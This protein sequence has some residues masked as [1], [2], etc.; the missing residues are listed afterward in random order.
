M[1]KDIVGFTS[2]MWSGWLRPRGSSLQKSRT[3][4]QK[5]RKKSEQIRKIQRIFSS[6][7]R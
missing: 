5:I 2:H 3:L 1:F 7:I 6:K 4:R